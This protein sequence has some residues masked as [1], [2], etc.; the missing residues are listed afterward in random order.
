MRSALGLVFLLLGLG[1]CAAVGFSFLDEHVL[2]GDPV[3]DSVEPEEETS[4]VPL[5]GLAL[6][7]I[8]LAVILL[9]TRRTGR[10]ARPENG[11]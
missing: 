3:P 10:N 11:D 9:G 8:G 2:V 6:V 7:A 5:L 1:L 4:T